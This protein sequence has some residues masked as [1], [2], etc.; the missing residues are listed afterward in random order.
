M[1]KPMQETVLNKLRKEKITSTIIV[2]NGFQIKN[3]RILSIDNFAIFI[4][5]DGKQMM[6]FK[7]AVSS[8][9][10]NQNIDLSS[11]ADDDACK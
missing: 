5:A 10:P 1:Q 8:I 9:S 4:E 2:T 11:E 3:S 6:L 7:H